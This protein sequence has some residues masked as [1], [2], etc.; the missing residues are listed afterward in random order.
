MREQKI[1]H[2]AISN[3]A[4]PQCAARL[5]GLLLLPLCLLLAHC[6]RH[7]PPGDE[8]PSLPE[9]FT[10]NASHAGKSVGGGEGAG[11]DSSGEPR[12]DPNAAV[13][14]GGEL[15][16]LPFQPTG[17]KVGSIA[18]R[19]WVY[20][21]TGKARTRYGYLRAGAV[22]DRRGPAIVNDGCAGG[23]YRINPR[24]F[25]CV[26]KGATLDLDH[27]VLKASRVRPVRGAGFPYPY[28]LARETSPYLYF[29]LPSA[30]EMLQVEGDRYKVNAAN[31]RAQ[32]EQ[33][34]L[35]TALAPSGEVPPFLTSG[36]SL[37][38]PYGTERGLHRTVEAGQSGSDS[39]FALLEL[40][41]YQE[42]VWGVST[43]L[44][45]LALDRT[46]VVKPSEFHGIALQEG[47]GLPVAIVKFPWIHRYRRADDGKF[48]E[49]GSLA[50]RT[51]LA[52]T[53]ERVAAEGTFWKTREGF[54]VEQS[55]VRLV[56]KRENFPSI[57]TGARKWIDVSINT[58]TLVAYLGRKPVYVTL[59]S[60]G[61]GLLGDP[62]KTPSTVRGTFMV[63][64]KHVS[65]T[66]DGDDDKAD[67]FNL[68]DV[69]FV[70]YFH[71]GYALHGTYWHDDFGR[72]RSHGCV[73][74]SPIDAAWLFE[75]TDPSVPADWHSVLNKERGTAVHIHP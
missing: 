19:T 57:A 20:S 37:E 27:P 6:D 15:D 49:D 31:W 66:M 24:G 75:W 29:R 34:G 38:K 45:L 36:Q 1:S 55:A 13:E 60:T 59:V 12:R 25:V 7:R 44:D 40:F 63:Y 48:L 41:T 64:A 33:N 5:S 3:R 4:I 9:A 53:G 58:Q 2:R 71:K 54:W 50:R 65:E 22:V 23:W 52:L 72:A 61:A 51:V 8:M 35:L 39:G 73:N 62:D 56:P 16:N 28:A 43:Q 17:E 68:R 10:V 14:P 42:R 69:P 67:S 21:D 18:W 46:N 47:E 70:Q 11:V 74:L 26:G 32:A 30:S